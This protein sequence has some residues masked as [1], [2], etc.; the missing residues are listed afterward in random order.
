MPT[1]TRTYSLVPSFAWMDFNPLC[2]ALPPP[3]FT[4][5]RP[6]SRSKSSWTTSSSPAPMRCARIS[7]EMGPPDVFI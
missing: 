4:R 3:T 1:R 7:F 2:P 5:M 6:G